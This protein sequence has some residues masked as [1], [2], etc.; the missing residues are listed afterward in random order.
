M[1]VGDESVHDPEGVARSDEER[2]FAGSRA[3]GAVFRRGALQGPHHDLGHVE[4]QLLGQHRQA[5]LGDQLQPA[6]FQQAQLLA[7]LAQL[8]RARLAYYEAKLLQ[9]TGQ[10]ANAEK[11]LKEVTIIRRRGG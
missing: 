11:L 7:P 2:S 10:S 9:A 6:L 1:E 4:A 3:Y 5:G 8:G